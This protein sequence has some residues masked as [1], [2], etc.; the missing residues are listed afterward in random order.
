MEVSILSKGESLASTWPTVGV[1]ATTVAVNHAA[2][3]A[4]AFPPIDWLFMADADHLTW[5]EVPK[6]W[7]GFLTFRPRCGVVTFPRSLESAEKVWPGCEIVSSVTLERVG[8]DELPVSALGALWFATQRLGGTVLHLH[9]FDLGGRNI[10]GNEESIERGK[11]R[12][13][14][15][16]EILSNV[17]RALRE[18][19]VVIHSYGAY[20]P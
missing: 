9:G 1:G 3:V 13:K 16:R 10:Y 5:D 4:P 19:G 12:W 2:L 11:R 15:E 6:G 17:C 20:K 18:R 7:E 14:S 8:Y